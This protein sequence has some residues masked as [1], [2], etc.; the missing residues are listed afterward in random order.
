MATLADGSIARQPRNAA[1]ASAAGTATVVKI[2]LGLTGATRET[3]VV[4]R[5]NVRRLHATPQS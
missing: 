3:N 5:R 1:S 2:A 4:L